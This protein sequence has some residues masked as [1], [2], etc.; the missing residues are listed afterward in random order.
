[1]FHCKIYD[2]HFPNK[3]KQKYNKKKSFHTH[4]ILCNFTKMSII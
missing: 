4:K 2:E 1:M 3:E